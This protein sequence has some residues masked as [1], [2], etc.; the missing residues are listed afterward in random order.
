[1]FSVLK[2]SLSMFSVPQNNFTCPGYFLRQIDRI[3]FKNLQNQEKFYQFKT[4][5]EWFKQQQ[6]WKHIKS[7]SN[8]IE[9]GLLAKP[10]ENPLKLDRS[11][12]WME[13]YY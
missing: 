11:C 6:I 9:E 12:A 7:L 8:N 4:E 13:F 3:L 1:M 10:N 5:Q 2:A